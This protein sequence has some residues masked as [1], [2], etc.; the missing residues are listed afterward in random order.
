M[1]WAIWRDIRCTE[2]EFYTDFNFHF[3]HWF[4]HL[5]KWKMA[6]YG[7]EI[8]GFFQKFCCFVLHLLKTQLMIRI[9]RSGVSAVKQTTRIDVILSQLTFSELQKNTFDAKMA[10][11]QKIVQTTLVIL[12]FFHF[13]RWP[14]Q[15]QKWN[16]CK[17]LILCN[18]YRVKWSYPIPPYWA[19]PLLTNM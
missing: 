6:H 14:N 17:V 10:K 19:Y 1:G 18:E 4:G 7:F 16:Q 8:C 15:W 13:I 3:C 11:E 9:W 2:S 12:C 5:M